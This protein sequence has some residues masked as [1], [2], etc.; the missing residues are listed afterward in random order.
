MATISYAAIEND[1]L[2]Q[3]RQTAQAYA[4]KRRQEAAA[5]LAAYQK[6]L[7]KAYQ[8]KWQQYDLQIR[9]TRR[10]SSPAYSDASVKAALARRQIRERLADKGLSGSGAEAA[11][12]AAAANAQRVT[13]RSVRAAEED[14]VNELQLELSAAYTAMLQK[15]REKQLALNESAEADIR[16]QT[17]S[18]ESTART[19]AGQISRSPKALALWVAGHN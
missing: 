2:R 16:K 8:D 5:S 10:A 9:S 14:A 13:E 18:L 7:D 4:V 1:L 11:G 3:A 19:R 6:E 15:Q 12:L 17:A